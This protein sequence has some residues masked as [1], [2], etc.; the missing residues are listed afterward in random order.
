[1]GAGPSPLARK[2]G[3]RAYMRVLA[4]DPPPGFRDALAPLPEGAQVAEEPAAGGAFD[5]VI[6]FVEREVAVADALALARAALSDGGTLWFA[7][8]KG[9]SGVETDL[10]RD[11]G[12]EALTTAGL[13]PVSQVAV[14]DVWSALRFRPLGEVG[15]RRTRPRSA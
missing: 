11:R 2:L 4:L 8:P 1:M 14:D 12:W 6:A 9:G 15:S 7:Y 13:R 10:S 5:V 3:V